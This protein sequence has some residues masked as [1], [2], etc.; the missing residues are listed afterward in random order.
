MKKPKVKIVGKQGKRATDE[1]RPNPWNPNSQSE[2]MFEKELGSIR[3]FGFIDPLTVRT[4]NQDGPFADGMAEII[5]GEHRWLAAKKLG[6]KKVSL[7]DLGNVP[8]HEAKALTIALN[9]LHGEADK[10]KLAGL[11][12]GLV[13][14][15]PDVVDMLPFSDVEIDAFDDIVNFDWDSLD[16]TDPNAGGG[17]GAETFQ[18]KLSP[19][20]KEIVDKAIESAKKSS[21]AKNSGEAL[22]M[23]AA[24]YLESQR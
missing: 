5:D 11:V 7:Q 3:R 6:L 4:G 22:V 12:T 2:F 18:V 17:D 8:D 24:A 13:G 19:E 15:F 23:V 9:E 10:V 21:D 1:F 14:D 20:Q 16:P